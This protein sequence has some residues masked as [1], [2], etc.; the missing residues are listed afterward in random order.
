MSEKVLHCELESESLIISF[1]WPHD[2]LTL[3]VRNKCFCH[4]TSY[5]TRD[6]K[7]TT[8]MTVKKWEWIAHDATSSRLK[9]FHFLS[10][11]HMLG[12]V[13]YSWCNWWLKKKIPAQKT[14][15][16][17]QKNDYFHWNVRCSCDQECKIASGQN[18]QI[19]PIFKQHIWHKTP[20][21]SKCERKNW[22]RCQ[23]GPT[24]LT[25]LQ[26]KR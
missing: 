26:T 5:Y 19:W 22:A 11:G 21:G 6:K 10:F 3:F 8:T 17:F 4:Y 20:T 1:C 14:Q 15:R 25:F 24:F 12:K 16:K 2:L 7:E 13:H 9:K 23:K 18:D